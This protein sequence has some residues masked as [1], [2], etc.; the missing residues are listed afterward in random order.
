M[1][2]VD[3][4]FQT[5]R[6]FFELP[7][8]IKNQHPVSVETLSG[9]SFPQDRYSDRTKQKYDFSS[10]TV[11]IPDEHAP[12]LRASVNN[13]ATKLTQLVTQVLKLLALALGKILSHRFS[14][15]K[16]RLI[17]L[18]SRIGRGLSK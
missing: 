9:Y 11:P 12:E 2:Q 18:L 4:V 13:L 16:H 14:H 15:C 7:L 17:S 1:I 6:S 5:S 10:P 3:K 8:E